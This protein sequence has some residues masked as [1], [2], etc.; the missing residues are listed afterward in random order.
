MDRAEVLIALPEAEAVDVAPQEA[1][2]VL[3]AH[4]PTS[5]LL[6]AE[7]TPKNGAKSANCRHHGRL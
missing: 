2:T 7:K 4:R 3:R 5:L 6:S 1:G